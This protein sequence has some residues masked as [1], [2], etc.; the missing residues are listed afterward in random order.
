MPD[1]LI[2]FPCALAR[3]RRARQDQQHGDPGRI[4]PGD[5]VHSTGGRDGFAIE[6]REETITMLSEGVRYTL[7]RRHVRIGC[8]DAAMDEALEAVL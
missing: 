7:S 5:R 8:S 2:P 3:L 6:I 1:N 4:R